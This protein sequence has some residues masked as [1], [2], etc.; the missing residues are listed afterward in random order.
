MGRELVWIWY[1]SGGRA[2][3][4]GRCPVPFAEWLIGGDQHGAALVACADELEQHAG[5]G[6]ILGDVSEIIKDQ[7]IEAI[8]TI[9]GRLE[10]E[11]ASRQLELLHE[12]GGPGEEDAPSVLDEGQADRCRQV[13]LS[14]AG[15][16]EQQQIGALAQPA[17]PA[18]S[19]ITCAFEIIGTASKSK[20]SKVFPAGKRAS[21]RCRSIRRRP[22]SAISCS[23]MVARK[24]PAG[25]PSLSDCSAN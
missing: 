25:Q 24:R 13:A 14:A 20:L 3:S 15:R 1:Q 6:L 19:A 4:L 18:A 11:L 22:R 8:E 7:E 10:V 12:I 21:T 16:A 5:L 17:V 23:A 2:C 9:D